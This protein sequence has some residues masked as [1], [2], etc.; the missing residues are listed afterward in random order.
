MRENLSGIGK[1]FIHSLT[2]TLIHST[3][4]LKRL[5]HAWA[6]SLGSCCP[7]LPGSH[8]EEHFGCGDPVFLPRGHLHRATIL[9]KV[10]QHPV[11]KTETFS[12]CSRC[13]SDGF[14]TRLLMV[15]CRLALLLL[16][17][18][19]IPD[20]RGKSGV[21]PYFSL[22]ANSDISYKS[23]SNARSGMDQSEGNMRA[24]MWK[25]NRKVPVPRIRSILVGSAC[26]D[27][28]PSLVITVKMNKA[29]S[30]EVH[31][32]PGRTIGSC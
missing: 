21:R 10:D 24:S 27:R 9:R 29:V 13:G 3:K 20:P 18:V 14:P 8:P 17:A 31:R 32:V 6:Q 15:L 28:V 11:R 1:G 23:V 16:L 30:L 4:P 5:C 26:F 12:P 19:L 2:S 22:L 7:C 25:L